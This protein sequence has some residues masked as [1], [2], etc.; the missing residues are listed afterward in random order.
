[1]ITEGKYPGRVPTRGPAKLLQAGLFDL[2]PQEMQPIWFLVAEVFTGEISW[3]EHTKIRHF[4]RLLKGFSRYFDKKGIGKMY[5]YM[6][7]YTILLL[8]LYHLWA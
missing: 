3:L 4:S 8:S 1:M 5:M 7:S 2:P 6:P